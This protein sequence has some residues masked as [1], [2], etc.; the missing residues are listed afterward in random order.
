LSIPA[1]YFQDFFAKPRS[2]HQAGKRLHALFQSLP[3]GGH[4]EK[5]LLLGRGESL[6]GRNSKCK[7]FGA[8]AGK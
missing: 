1:D 8:G 2:L 3:A 5:T 6:Q 7:V 4:L